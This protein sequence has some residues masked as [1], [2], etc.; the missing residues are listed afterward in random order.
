MST[1]LFTHRSHNQG[2]AFKAYRARQRKSKLDD[3]AEALANGASP[4]EAAEALGHQASYGR[5][6][7]QRIVKKLGKEQCR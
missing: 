5:T 1:G 4:H 6:L 3:F 2:R 7:F